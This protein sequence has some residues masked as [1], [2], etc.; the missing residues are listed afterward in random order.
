[1]KKKK[2]KKKGNNNNNNNNKEIQKKVR[3]QKCTL[4]AFWREMNKHK[5]Q[6]PLHTWEIL[7]N[8]CFWPL[9]K[10]FFVDIMT[11]EQI[12]KKEIDLQLIHKHYKSDTKEF[13]F[14]KVVK[15]ITLDDVKQVFGLPTEGNN[16]TF[17]KKETKGKHPLI[18]KHFSK[19]KDAPTK[20][21]VSKALIDELKDNSKPT[22]HM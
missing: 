20:T 9:I 2:K 14:G 11:E 10:P 21:Q 19:C 7:R 18:S 16:F 17:N 6:I 8:T 5:N 4:V 22:Q 15:K 13:K 12:T 3:Q 1:M